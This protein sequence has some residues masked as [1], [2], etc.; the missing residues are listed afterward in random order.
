MD[1]QD[2]AALY[3]IRFPT[4]ELER[5]NEIWKVLCQHYFQPLIGSG[6]VVVDLACGYGEFINNI[7]AREKIAVDLN[8]ESKQFLA[9]DVNFLQLDAAEL[10]EN[11]CGRA[12]VIFTSN[13]LEHLP[14]KAALDS[15]LHQVYR[16]LRPGGRFMILGP[17][18]RYLPGQYWD[19]YD[20]TL[21]LTHLSLS[22]ALM[23]R[24]YTVERCVNR[25]LPYTTQGALP[26]HPA[27]V[28]A[29][30]ACP[31]LWKLLGKQFFIIAKRAH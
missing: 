23:L 20:H 5:K 14:D 1:E 9:S 10:G 19:Y 28:R 18:L 25:F 7:R 2:L 26:T 16:A 15:L 13:F 29:Y 12:D 24:G 11:L 8:P 21:G 31:P 6:N 22:E 3:R 27:L 30:L 17:N 4:G